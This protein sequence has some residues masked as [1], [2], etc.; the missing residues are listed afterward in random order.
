[1]RR[2]LVLADHPPAI[3]VEVPEQVELLHTQGRQ[4]HLAVNEY[5]ARCRFYPYARLRKGF[6]IRCG[7]RGRGVVKSETGRRKLKLVPVLQ[8]CRRARRQTVPVYENTILA[9]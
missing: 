8:P 9:L 6:Q 5:L 2:Q 1:M 4:Q 3:L 7:D